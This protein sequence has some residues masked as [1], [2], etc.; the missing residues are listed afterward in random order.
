MGLG[1]ADFL[2]LLHH[3]LAH[4]LV[5]Q[6]R[7]IG[8]GLRISESFGHDVLQA[9]PGVC[10]VA[11]TGPR[12]RVAGGSRRHDGRQQGV[13]VAVGAQAQESQGVARAL[14]LHPELVPATAVQ[15]EIAPLE[16]FL[17]GFAVGKARHEDLAVGGLGDHGKQVRFGPGQ[18]SDEGIGEGDLA[19]IQGHAELDIAA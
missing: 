4:A 18:G 10:A 12:A 8:T 3:L 5:V 16:A 15:A 1:R 14:A 19:G 2:G 9:L 6:G 13:A 7:G 11:E 17:D